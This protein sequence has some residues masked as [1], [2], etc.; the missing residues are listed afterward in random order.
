VGDALDQAWD[1]GFWI[2]DFRFVILDWQVEFGSVTER[3]NSESAHRS[4]A[5]QT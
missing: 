2:L 4:V 1:L 5:L 3:V